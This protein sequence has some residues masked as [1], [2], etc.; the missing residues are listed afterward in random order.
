MRILVPGGYGLIGS[1]IVSALLAAGHEVTGLGRSVG[2]A[3]LREPRARWLQHDLQ[4]LVSAEAWRPLLDDVDAVINA[5]GVLQDG[6]GDDV[7]VTQS[8]AMVALFEACEQAG[9]KRFV[10]ISAVG[11]SPDAATVFMRSKGIADEALEGSSLDWTIL[12][13]GLVLGS[14]AYGGSALL[15]A[16]ASLP[17]F[18]PLPPAPSIRSVALDDVAA[19]ALA[20]VEARLPHRR[21]YDLVEDRAHSLQDIVAA[22]R[23][24][25]G[26]PPARF[27]RWPLWIFR[28]GFRLGDLAGL[29]G[30]RP[31]M[32]ST[33]LDQILSGIDGDPTPLG[34]ANGR[35]LKALPEILEAVGGTVR[36][37]WFARLFLLKPVIIATLGLFWLLSGLIGLFAADQA[38]VVLTIRGFSPAMAALFVLG[39]AIVDILLGAGIFW[40]RT[41]PAAATGMISVTLAYLLAGSLFTPDLW[42]D[43]L[44]PFL[45]TLPA[46]VLALVAL[47]I[48]DAR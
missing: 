33:S 16:L 38:E 3:R 23:A 14:S 12:R 44:G 10:Q 26:L 11:A 34:A 21:I 17:G 25:L 46:A 8:L 1:A 20:A 35:S 22:L 19:T 4:D 37:R 27:A 2:Q 24:R 6:P 13:P 29:L 18:I 5:A 41:M 47:A 42:L 15:H 7:M 9:V 43:P 39:G 30:W 31:P 48:K 28:L 32:R 36:E 45:K 40:R